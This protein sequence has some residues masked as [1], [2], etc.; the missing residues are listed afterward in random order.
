MLARHASFGTVVTAVALV[1]AVAASPRASLADGPRGRGWVGIAMSVPDGSLGVKVGHVIHGS[2][3]EKAG[4][5]SDDRITHVDDALVTT[6]R[7]VVLALGRHAVGDSAQIT[8]VR[9]GA[10]QRLSVVLAEYPSSDVMLRMDRVGNPAPAWEGLTPTSGFPSSLV[11]LRGRVIVI[12]FWA[13]WCGPCRE[14]APVISG[15]AARYGAEGLSVV[16]ITTD[17]AEV[18]A[19]F[20]DRLDLRYPMAS[21]PHAS[22][23]L[24]YG[25]SA[26][27]T[28][29]VVDKRGVV[30]DV[31]VGEEPGQEA[32]IE[33]LIR[34]LLAE[35]ASNP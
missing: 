20:K 12:D 3:A 17:S 25:V 11:G 35:P 23:S 19:R 16:G 5:Q 4:V 7:D 9:A 31:A 15:W 24:A 14:M 32:R 28:L 22:T 6:S 30:R 29:F 8:I 18:A 27:P 21:D 26:L 33:A 10:T 34:V 2:P 13:T 1:L